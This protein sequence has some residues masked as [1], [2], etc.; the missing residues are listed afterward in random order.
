[1]LEAIRQAMGSGGGFLVHRQGMAFGQ[2][3]WKR[4]LGRIGTVRTRARLEYAFRVWTTVGW[5]R[6]RVLKLAIAAG[7]ASLRLREG[8]E[9][10]GRQSAFPYSQ[11]LRGYLAGAFSVIFGSEATCTE[12]KCV[13][14]GDDACEFEIARVE[15]TARP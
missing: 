7:T 9:C 13:A 8:A 12:T 15:T 2:A 14:K 10:E 4:Y 11:F 3:A 5:G 1:M 6:M